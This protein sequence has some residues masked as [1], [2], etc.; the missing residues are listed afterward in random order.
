[1]LPFHFQCPLKAESSVRRGQYWFTCC[2]IALPAFKILH[3]LSCEISLSI[4]SENDAAN[5][6]NDFLRP[7]LSSFTMRFRVLL[8]CGEYLDALALPDRPLI[9]YFTVPRS[10]IL[11]LVFDT[12]VC[13][14]CILRAISCLK[15]PKSYKTLRPSHWFTLTDRL[16]ML[17]KLRNFGDFNEELK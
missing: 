1:M 15:F 5:C 2:W 4:C 9:R 7:S 6:L 11:F 12:N 8:S 13:G 10:W 3:T 17:R 14:I 16:P